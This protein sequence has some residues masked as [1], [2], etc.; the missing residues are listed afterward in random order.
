MKPFLLAG[1]LATAS[2]LLATP[3]PLPTAPRAAVE[4]TG[5]IIDAEARLPLEFATV[6]VFTLDSALVTGASTDSLGGFRVSVPKGEYRV[7]AEFIGYVA[8]T[9]ELTVRRGLDLGDFVLTADAVAL[10]GATVT[11]QRSRLSLKLDKQVFD[12]AA[13]I[14]SAG[15]S[16]NEVLENVPSVDVSPE[17]VVSLRG[18]SGVKILING[19]PSTL[20]DNNALQSIPAENI[21]KVEIIT[22]PSARYEASGV[23]GIINIVL[24]DDSSR[25][26][27]GQVSASVG[28]PTD[29]R[30]NGS[31]SASEK[32]W[33][34]FGNAGLRYSEYFSTGAADRRSLLATGTQLLRED[35]TQDRSDRAWNAYGGF[36]YR[37]DAATTL[38]ASYS[39]YYQLDDDLSD[40][41]YD[42][43]DGDGQ[44]RRT[45]GQELSLRKPARYNQIEVSVSRELRG[46]DRKLFVLFQNDFWSSD[47]REGT[48]LTERF[49]ADQLAFL[50]ETDNRQSSRDYLLQADYE[51]PLGAHGKLEL[52][53]RGETR[54]ISSD[55]LA[56]QVKDGERGVFLGFDNEVDYHEHIGAAY[57]QYAY[58]N[59]PWGVQA[60]LRN[61]YSAIRVERANAE[62]SGVGGGGGAPPDIVKRYNNLFP[63]ATVSREWSERW[64]ANVSYTSRIRRPGFWTINPFGGVNNPNEIRLGNPD[65]DARFVD[66][67]EVKALYNGDELT[68]NPFFR[69]AYVHNFYDQYATQ[70]STGLVRLLQIDLDRETQIGGGLTFTYRL[71]DDWQVN[72]EGYLSRFVQRGAYEGVDFGNAFMMQSLQVGFRGRLP[73][74]IR[75]EATL[76]YWGGQRYAQFFN[77][78]VTALRAG[79]S[80]KFL[81]DRL[82][83]SLNV[84]N[85]FGLQKF[86]GGS[87]RASFTNTY[88][89]VWQRERWL[90]TAAWDIG[91][92][93]RQRRARGRIR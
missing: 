71:T 13:D 1:A 68:V 19:K 35:L 31:F 90:L 93:V 72:G 49:P 45:L 86:S 7:V 41:T 21:A 20:A 83:L 65:I 9:R 37:P 14:T 61:E 82:Q 70:D 16:A 74:D 22:S 52:G 69:L 26:V 10:D 12:V 32:E 89:R 50:L 42:Y 62:A 33:T 6:S 79:A 80:R 30:L 3:L 39:H 60:G 48:T 15:G 63:S 67:F 2:A 64:S 17:G 92:D 47:E 40:V 18:S 25:S 28:V 29:G 44:L 84:R 24:R 88:E 54:V 75:C 23:G 77:N 56:E 11:A 76:D 5:R 8:A 59:G 57:A 27:G 91:K 87:S 73:A 85:L 4:L 46:T 34:V 38:S 66:A 58:E 81:D 43:R 36:D 55:Y 51:Q 53:L 78:P